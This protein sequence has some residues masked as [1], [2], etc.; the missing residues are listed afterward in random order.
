MCSHRKQGKHP[1]SQ[2]T[3]GVASATLLSAVVP[4]R[5]REREGGDEGRKGGRKGADTWGE[6]WGGENP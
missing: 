4:T 2:N 6:S 5:R 1:D 3:E